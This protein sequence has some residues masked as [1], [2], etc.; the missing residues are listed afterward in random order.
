MEPQIQKLRLRPEHFER[1]EDLVEQWALL[2]THF[3]QYSLNRKEQH[4][5]SQ[6]LYRIIKAELKQAYAT[7][8][9]AHI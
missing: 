8:E 1:I 9:A 3:T 6:K 5:E 2:D 4:E 7:R